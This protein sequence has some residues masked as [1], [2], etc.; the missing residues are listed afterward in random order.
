MPQ[1]PAAPPS[2]AP[3]TPDTSAPAVDHTPP[4]SF[5]SL[6]LAPELAR[7]AAAAGWTAPRPLQAAAW[8]L[9]LAGR[10]VLARAPTGTGKTAA[11]LLPLLQR[12]LQDP[13]LLAERPRRLQVLVLAPTRDLAAQIH[14]AAVAL[15]PALKTVLAVGGVSINPQM[16]A[17]RGGAHLVVATPGRVLD[18]SR[19]NALRLNEL[20]TVVLDEAD[21]LLDSGFAEETRRVL[22]LLPRPRQTLLFSATL[23]AEVLAVAAK[24]QTQAVPL[25]AGAGD[26]DEALP[27]ESLALADDALQAQAHI[28]Q[29]ALVVDTA[30]RT[31]LLRHLLKTEGWQRCLVFVATQY[32]AEL[33][34]DKLARHG[35]AAAAL[36]GQLSPGRRQQVLQALQHA[37][38][39]VVVATDLAA[40]G[41]HVPGLQAVVNHDLPR[42]PVDHVHRIG[43]TGRGGAAGTAI[44]FVCADAPGSEAHFRLIEKRQ[45]QRV[46]R[47]V[48]PGFEPAPGA[49]P[50]A[51]VPD[52]ATDDAPR[53]LDPNGGVKGRRKSKKDKLR[54]AAA[55]GG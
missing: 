4:A 9:V 52:G 44:S 49:A 55:R 18:L 36:H 41:L 1:T 22:Q 30:R 3:D 2:P 16:L 24:V 10:D 51:A 21:R 33:V 17:L 34:A 43:R 42:S 26:D 11:F 31:P 19:Q 38:L 35:V 53:G 15:A 20:A 50:A 5:Q 37:E 48:V 28:Q 39:Q 45:R 47:E 14:A 12:L 54:E 8:P 40:R 25:Q 7:A 46:P 32:A 29:R 23:P 6:G 13:A 27:A